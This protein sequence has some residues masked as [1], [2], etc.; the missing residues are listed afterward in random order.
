MNE[1]ESKSL[2]PAEIYN[3][4]VR[5]LKFAMTRLKEY[6]MR[7]TL[8]EDD[9]APPHEE[10][11]GEFHTAAED[12]GKSAKRRLISPEPSRHVSPLRSRFKPQVVKCSAFGESLSVSRV[13]VSPG[14]H[15]SGDTTLPIAST[16]PA[17]IPHVRQRWT[18]Q[19]VEDLRQ[20]YTA[21]GPQWMVIRDRFPSLSS[22]TN[23]QLKD[24]HRHL[25]GRH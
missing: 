17:V 23:V 22:F 3:G 16:I 25:V 7:S 5:H 8:D 4:L 14:R 13:S 21:H 9:V 10:E 20:G 15:Q 24:K 1:P 18:E 19:Q 12:E 11:D 6:E 2:M